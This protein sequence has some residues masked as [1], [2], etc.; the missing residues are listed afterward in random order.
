[1]NSPNFPRMESGGFIACYDDVSLNV[2]VLTRINLYTCVYNE[3]LCLAGLRGELK[4]EGD[5]SLG[6]DP[7][8][9]RS[10]PHF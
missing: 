1:M 6:L 9:K 7:L 3:L 4:S 10:G 5:E 2:Y 8:Q